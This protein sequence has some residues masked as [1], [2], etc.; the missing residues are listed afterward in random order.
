[1]DWM[2]WTAHSGSHWFPRLTPLRM[3]SVFISFGWSDVDFGQET[4]DRPSLMKSSAIDFSFILLLHGYITWWWW[5]CCYETEIEF[6]TWTRPMGK[7]EGACPLHCNTIVVACFHA[8]PLCWCPLE[9]PE[10]FPGC[11][12]VCMYVFLY[13]GLVNSLAG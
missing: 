2:V 5:C 9:R 12:F 11:W 3:L 13:I 1:M 6:H 4:A 10:R 8:I 7:H